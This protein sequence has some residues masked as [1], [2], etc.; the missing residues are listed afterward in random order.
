MM[1]S[2]LTPKAASTSAE[3]MPV[4]PLPEVQWMTEGKT[5]GHG[6]LAHLPD[7]A[8]LLLW[9]LRGLFHNPLRDCNPGIFR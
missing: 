7:I 1:A 9:D 8:S 6:F 2:S 3:T 5:I 4:R